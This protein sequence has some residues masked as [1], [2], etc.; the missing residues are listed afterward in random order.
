MSVSIKDLLLAVQKRP[1][2]Y[3]RKVSFDSVVN[4]IDIFL[5]TKRICGIND[6]A[7]DYFSNH[8]HLWVCKYFNMDEKFCVHWDKIIYLNSFSD[9]D[10]IEKYFSLAQMFFDQQQA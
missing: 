9:E 1:C 5:S 2:L 10:A 8:F 7:D 3:M 6:S 4:Y